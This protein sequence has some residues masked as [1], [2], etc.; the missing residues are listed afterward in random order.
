MQIETNPVVRRIKAFYA[1]GDDF[2]FSA[3]VGT[4]SLADESLV[5][6]AI[7]VDAECRR[8]RGLPI[9]FE[10]YLRSVPWLQSSTAALDAAIEV[11][12]M[13]DAGTVKDYSQVRLAADRLKAKFPS[14]AGDIERSAAISELLAESIGV[15]PPQSVPTPLP[16]LPLDYGAPDLDGRPRYTLLS[17]LGSGSQSR[18]YLAA[19]RLLSDERHT[20][21]VAIKISRLC[22]ED[23]HQSSAEASR[24]RRVTHPSVARV[25]DRGADDSGCAY[26]VYEHISGT[27]LD[28]WHAAHPSRSRARRAA[29]MVQRIAWGVQAIH[30]AGVLHLDLKPSN[31]LID[32]VGDPKVTDF[33]SA[34]LL[35]PSDEVCD[36]G[37][38]GTLAFM[39]PEQFLGLSELIS[40]ASD[41]F[42]LGGLLYWTLSNE[43]PNGRTAGEAAANLH[44]GQSWGSH[45][46][47]RD[48]PPDL[49]AICH[50]AMS[51]DPSARYSSADSLAAD[52]QR[53]LEHRPVVASAPTWSRRAMLAFRRRRLVCGVA[54]IALGISG[55]VVAWASAQSERLRRV[56]AEASLAIQSEKLDASEDKR[57]MAAT[58]FRTFLKTLP[59]DTQSTSD[60][61]WV[62]SFAVIELMAD[63]GILEGTPD[64]LLAD[65]KRID[66]VR[67]RLAH[68]EAA[69]HGHTL[70]SVMWRHTLAE[71]LALEGRMVEA[72]S[73]ADRALDGY[74]RLNIPT[75]DPLPADLLVRRAGWAKPVSDPPQD[76]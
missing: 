28:K 18:V 6:D 21:M 49:A 4:A 17:L 45:L 15:A 30:T 48:V 26:I 10:R 68:L 11:S 42:A 52:L 29:Q 40:P 50:R 56:S 63:R 62:P 67:A 24:A 38:R 5:A 59:T 12:L 51:Y 19:D 71:W 32:A 76:E 14:L 23:E 46:H 66:A 33:G 25:L 7:V 31:V 1:T 2:D 43:F 75:I 44:S 54:I 58:L 8:V 27:T 57:A 61:G 16:R 22:S 41:V 3:V 70:E 13:A 74:S 39:S 20:A 37:A 53:F 34:R 35:R 47:F 72:M 36:Y 55:A 73:E 60:L 65:A 9:L 64:L 69:A